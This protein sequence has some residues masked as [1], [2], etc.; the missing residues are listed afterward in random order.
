MYEL[1]FLI[2]CL[3]TCIGKF[4][5]NIRDVVIQGFHNRVMFVSHGF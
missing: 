3:G 5:K 4:S 2:F 1:F